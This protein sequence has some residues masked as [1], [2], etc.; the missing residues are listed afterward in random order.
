[1]LLVLLI[2]LQNRY[3]YIV[4]NVET[5]KLKNKYI[6][7]VKCFLRNGAVWVLLYDVLNLLC[8]MSMYYHHFGKN[9]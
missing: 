1:M 7:R 2:K 5:M 3:F 8:I 9:P 4:K 6:K